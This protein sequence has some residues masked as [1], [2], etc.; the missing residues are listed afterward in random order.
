V[1]KLYIQ[2]KKGIKVQNYDVHYVLKM[3]ELGCCE[4]VSVLA[5]GFIA[6]N[7]YMFQHPSTLM[8]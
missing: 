1:V 4:S 6:K 3:M 5:R 8:Q 7:R 2:L